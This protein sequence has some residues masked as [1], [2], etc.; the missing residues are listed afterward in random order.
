MRDD[1]L[2][3]SSTTKSS[4]LH[5]ESPVLPRFSLPLRVVESAGFV[6]LVTAILYFMGYSYYAGFFARISLPPPYPELSTS[7][8]FLRAFSSV[9]GLIAA[10]LVSIPFRSGVP[11]TIWQALW[12]NGAFIIVP[13]LLAQNARSGEFLDRDLA[14][15]LGA[16][17]VVGVVASVLKRSLLQL[18]TGQWGLAGL[19]AYAFGFFLFFS[20]YFRLEGSADATKLVEGRLQ[21]SSSVILQTNDAASPANGVPLLI[22][23]ARGGDFYLVRQESPAPV[24]PLVYFVPGSEVR[25]ATMQR[26]G[27]TMATPTP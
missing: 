4:P 11:A 18:L 22:A 9:S 2:S 14:L 25:T 15:F 3:P 17:V 19:I 27:A 7:D 10:M 16:V 5:E 23:L 20:V 26:A 8:Y 1:P 12:L 6:A 24:A 21:P 13:L